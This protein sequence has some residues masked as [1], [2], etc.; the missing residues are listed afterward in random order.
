MEI[1]RRFFDSEVRA[2]EDTKKVKG[3]GSVFGKRSEDLGGFQ[4][5]I[6]E[7]AFDGRLRDD[8]RALFNHDQNIVL[9]R[10]K[11]GTL[12]L[13][14]DE[15]GLRYEVDF[16]DTQQARDLLVTIKRGDVD[17]S[18]FAFTVAHDGDEIT[19]IDGVL[20]R[21]IHKIKRLYDVSPVTYP[22][23]PDTTVGARSIKE[24]LKARS[25][26][27]GALEAHRDRLEQ[28]KNPRW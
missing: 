24:F 18:S 23:Y 6:A 16:P 3:Y 10:T 20:I 13:S 2:S 11:S 8:V 27:K 9:G 26:S 17:Q 19:E 21:T 5:I 12:D 7:G 28:L 4:E 14:I 25:I 22:A 15:K 1:E